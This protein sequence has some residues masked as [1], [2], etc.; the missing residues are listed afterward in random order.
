MRK[1]DP[2]RLVEELSQIEVTTPSRV[3]SR[4]FQPFQWL[5]PVSEFPGT[6]IGLAT[7]QRIIQKHGGQVWA[8]GAVGQ[9]ATFYFTLP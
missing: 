1:G 3:A 5:H 4:L 9:G 2:Q 8:E 7:A 6:G